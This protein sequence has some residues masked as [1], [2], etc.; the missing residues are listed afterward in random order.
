MCL[1]PRWR[2][3]HTSHSPAS[4]VENFSY[5]VLSSEV[6]AE[7][8]AKLKSMLICVLQ[9]TRHFGNL[10][11]TMSWSGSWA[12]RTI[13]VRGVQNVTRHQHPG[14]R[15]PLPLLLVS[16]GAQV[17]VRSLRPP[18]ARLET[19][20]LSQARL[21]VIWLETVFTCLRTPIMSVTQI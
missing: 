3:R 17:A 13:R 19:Q 5:H 8:Y 15:C 2:T 1:T 6:R 4:W 9:E 10:F 11:P 21:G 18:P 7:E 14:R 20:Y 12:R 16:P